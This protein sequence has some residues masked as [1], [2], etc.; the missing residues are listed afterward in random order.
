MIRARLRNLFAGV[1]PMG[2]VFASLLE[3]QEIV[4]LHGEHLLFG[5]G[6]IA[7]GTIC[8][9]LAGHFAKGETK[10]LPGA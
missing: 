4:V 6:L 8:A 1:A 10:Q 3:G 2:V 9:T 5:G 7:A